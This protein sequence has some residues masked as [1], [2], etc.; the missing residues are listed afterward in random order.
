MS[1]NSWKQYGGIYK[2]DKLHNV[3][4]GTLVADNILLRKIALAQ[5]TINGDLTITGTTSMS[6][7]LSLAGSASISSN[8]NLLGSAY[9][10]KFLYFGSSNNNSGFLYGL[11]NSSYIGLNNTAPTSTLDILGTGNSN[12]LRIHTNNA[13]IK[14]V[15]AEN[16]N[17]T[18]ITAEVNNGTTTIGFYNGNVS[19][20]TLPTSSISGVNGS[21][22]MT[23]TNAYINSTQSTNLNSSTT[24]IVSTGSNTITGGNTIIRTTG[25]SIVDSSGSNT[26]NSSSF[27]NINSLGGNTT[28]N[29]KYYTDISS[30]NIVL[31]SRGI[32]NNILGEFVTIYDTS[33][34]PFLYNYYQNSN[35]RTGE[36][37]TIVAVDNK[38][39][40]FMNITTPNGVGL[41]IGG[42]AYINDSTRNMGTLGITNLSGNFIPSQLI[43][44]GNSLIKYKTTV[45]F[46]TYA[47]KTETYVMDINGP[48]RIGNGEVTLVSSAGFEIKY[49][50]FSKR[51]GQTGYAVGSPSYLNPQPANILY[52]NNSGQNW[53]ISTIPITYVINNY[54]LYSYDQNFA[55]VASIQNYLFYTSNGGSVWKQIPD[56]NPNPYKN[57]NT[58][59]INYNSSTS[60]YRL[61]IC[62]YTTTLLPTLFYYDTTT[63]DINPNYTSSNAGTSINYS[64]ISLNAGFNTINDSDGSGNFMYVAGSGIQKIDLS[65]T[66][67]VAGSYISIASSNMYNSIFCY[68]LS[69]AI[70]VG[71]N[72]ISYTTDSTNWQNSTVSGITGGNYNLRSVY[73]YD[74]SN[75]VAV[76]DNGV[77][78][79]TT[80][81]PQ[82]WQIVPSYILNTSGLGNLITGTNN[83]LISVF[84]PDLNSFVI[85]DVSTNYVTNT[86]LGSSKI[87][88]GFYPN[89]FNRVNNKVA[90]V[91]GN[92]EVTG[93]I[94]I[95]GLGQLRSTNQTFYLLNDTVQTITMG[96]ATTTINV[97]G[98]VTS[99]QVPGTL[100]VNGDT[101]MNSRL[102]VTSDV[103]LNSRL[104]VA[105]DASFNNRILAGSDISL[106]GRL[107]VKQTLF[108]IG[109][110][111]MSSRLFVSQD[112]SFNNR[113]LAGS[114]VSMGGR[115]FVNGTSATIGDASF[116]TRVLVGSD[117]SMGGRLFVAGDAYVVGNITITRNLFVQ[118]LQNQ[119]IIN[120]TINN[121]QLIISEDISLNGRLFVS[122][123]VSLNSRLSV[124]QDASFNNRVLVGSD[125]SLGGRLFVQ[126][127]LFNI[128][129]VS[130]SS[131]LFVAQDASLNNRVLVGSDVSMGGRLFVQGLTFHIGDVSLNSR[132]FVAQDAS[133]NN[134]VLVGSDVS[135]GGRL[136]VQ[137][138]TFHIGDVSLNSR[139][140]VAQDAS[141]NNRLIVGSDVSLGGRLFVQG[142]LFNIGDVS[143]NSRLFVAQDASFNNRLIVGSDVS[144][145]GR[146]FVQG[147]LFNIGDVSLNSRMFVA[148][149]ASFNNRVLVGSDVSLGGRFFVQG[150]AYHAGDIS[151]N[152]NVNVT[153]S[154]YT[155]SIFSNAYD[156]TN[157]II[158]IGPS[159]SKTI[160]IGTIGAPTI[161]SNIKIGFGADS[162]FIG[163]NITFTNTNYLNVYAPII[164][165]NQQGYTTAAGAGIILYP[166][167]SSGQTN[168]YITLN[169]STGGTTSGYNFKVTSS[170]NV[171]DLDV[172]TLSLNGAATQGMVVLQQSPYGD[173]NNQITVNTNIDANYNST[174]KFYVKNKSILND[175]VSM[176]SRLFVG[177]DVSMNANAWI[178]NGNMIFGKNTQTV[179]N[180]IV[181]P[182]LDISGIMNQVGG[183]VFQ[184]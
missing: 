53:S 85:A 106:G 137:G 145:G 119:N 21:I 14:N 116:N 156:S 73:I 97:G 20:S 6:Q 102:F 132:L 66:P 91:S 31:S 41:S 81:G 37:L 124:S 33:N 120:T 46:N 36:A 155:N 72:V 141:L 11:P 130:M 117:V 148:Q 142:T 162:V 58:I 127:T 181:G 113:I 47:P 75:A 42:G 144:L 174:G 50:K 63:L 160:N 161:A 177:N 61:S 107:F 13:Y 150:V 4:V 64:S 154:V 55:F 54:C 135:M 70:A 38:S 8:F 101:S 60:K 76:G 84:M 146:L 122:G 125:V 22:T 149:D 121:Y 89:L 134:R 169:N 65:Q 157:S 9:L 77:F 151:T 43:V 180:G 16:S 28:I 86:T 163:G 133:F 67:P 139:L 179:L 5:T 25:Y 10:S 44:S 12:V 128:G 95:D 17:S 68:D 167:A 35:S 165:I 83:N 164:S 2:S 78:L 87:L 99:V 15:I 123:D 178:P 30:S 71:T 32:F 23:S 105:Q 80:N 3:S 109:D 52:T 93:D 159:I 48:M 29:S 108:N 26:I 138:V 24:N 103:S 153:T 129:D 34:S 57:F 111:S 140:F 171:V 136:F 18:G 143:L 176:N 49:M 96:T 40:T 118:Q 59:Y 45:G 27:V 82:N 112:A 175:D 51:N 182:Y 19:T 126:G 100:Y 110:V 94:L 74:L 183:L 173:S 92:M 158:N 184:F 88:Y 62:G 114:D 90:D 172:K 98:N 1:N 39:N 170:A 166:Q 168:G 104:F 152:G 115:L 79:Y 7:N 56:T 131:R 147:T 69:Y